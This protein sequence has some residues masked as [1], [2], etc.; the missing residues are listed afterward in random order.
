MFASRSYAI[1]AR[2]GSWPPGECQ[3]VDAGDGRPSAIV[4]EEPWPEMVLR[5]WPEGSRGMP[6]LMRFF[7]MDRNTSPTRTVARR[8]DDGRPIVRLHR[9]QPLFQQTVGIFDGEDRKIGYGRWPFKSGFGDR[10]DIVR[11]DHQVLAEVRRQ[12]DG[13]YR[14]AG[15]A[16]GAEWGTLALATGDVPPHRSAMINVTLPGV[17]PDVDQWEIFLLAA[18]LMLFQVKREADRQI[19]SAPPTVREQ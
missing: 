8:V 18:G 9:P 14:A 15:A 10:F 1:A 17:A 2:G 6:W 4:R 11:P 3:I 16:A 12:A 19:A 13:V 5:P 7:G